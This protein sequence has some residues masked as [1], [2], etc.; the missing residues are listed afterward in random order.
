MATIDQLIGTLTTLVSQPI[1]FAGS[2]TI[3]CAAAGS[4]A[5]GDVLSSTTTNNVGQATYVP[6]LSR[7][8]GQPFT[9][10]AIRATSSNTA[11]LSRMRCYWFTNQPTPVDVEMD[12]NAVFAIN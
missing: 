9:I 5:A 12:D 11:L 2:V 4:Y 7:T 1:R 3:S 10:V 6:H 8:A